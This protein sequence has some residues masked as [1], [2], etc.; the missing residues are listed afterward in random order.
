[1]DGPVQMFI[2][3]RYNDVSIVGMRLP[4]ELIN[5][6]SCWT[7]A[8]KAIHARNACAVIEYDVLVGY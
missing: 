7:G 6:P 8:I 5:V 2:N 3:A 1:M 4:V